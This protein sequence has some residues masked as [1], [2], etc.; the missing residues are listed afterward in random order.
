MG[1][2]ARARSRARSSSDFCSGAWIVNRW[3]ARPATAAVTASAACGASAGIGRLPSATVSCLARSI[4]SAGTTPAATSAVEH[5]IARG[6]RGGNGA[7][8][9]PDFRRLRQCDQQ[10]RFRERQ[11]PRLLA[12]IGQRCGT[13]A[14]K[15]AAIRREAKVKRE[16][17]V[18][19]QAAL[20]LDR[21]HDLPKLGDEA[22]LAARL[23]E[24]RHLHGQRR[25][26]RHDAAVHEQL[27]RGAGERQRID[28]VVVEEAAVLVGEQH[29]Q[30]AR[31]DIRAGRRQPPAALRR[32]VGPQQPP[33][34]IDHQRRDTRAP[35]RAVPG[36]ATQPTAS[37]HPSS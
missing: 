29:R 3:I 7:I 6:A 30:E 22:A 11:P 5:A 10:R 18:L 12:E 36:R 25:G 1:P 2:S 31:I 24:P 8:R 34:A 9:P 35:R 17:L 33:V 32:G 16:D 26:A 15:I 28:A 23:Q 19:A 27:R 14:F 37:S 4:S 13:N 20:E 21:A